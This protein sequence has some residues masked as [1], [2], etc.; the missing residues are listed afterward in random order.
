YLHDEHVHR[1]H[2]DH[3]DEC[4]SSGHQPAEEHIHVHGAGC[5]HAPVLHGDHLDY[6][7]D[8]HRHAAHEGHYDEH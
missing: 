5:G 2:D 1:P 4:A 7:H 3:Y 6:V 8:G